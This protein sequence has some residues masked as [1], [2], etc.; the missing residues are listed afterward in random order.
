VAPRGTYGSPTQGQPLFTPFTFQ[1]AAAPDSVRLKLVENKNL[2]MDDDR[3]A[4]LYKVSDEDSISKNLE[5]LVE[6]HNGKGSVVS[7]DAKQARELRRIIPIDVEHKSYNS[8]Y[9]YFEKRALEYVACIL[10]K[11]D[12]NVRVESEDEEWD[13]G[14]KYP[15]NWN[16]LRKAVYFRDDY[17]CTECGADDIEL[18][19]HHKQH[20][21]FDGEHKL[22]NL[23]A[24]CSECHSSHHGFEI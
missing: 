2:Y 23:R 6:E 7:G 15:D 19:A 3:I 9:L 4:E 16:I 8:T 17:T 14:E 21:E 11:N 1:I 20:I 5:V 18:H 13:Y 22:E 10:E 12:Y 24:L